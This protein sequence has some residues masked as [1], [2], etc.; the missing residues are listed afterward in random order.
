M[1]RNRYGAAYATCAGGEHAGGADA[2]PRRLPAARIL[3]TRYLSRAGTTAG[4]GMMT[5]LLRHERARFVLGAPH[6]GK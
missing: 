1:W 5:Y 3:Q 2:P 6:E 4:G